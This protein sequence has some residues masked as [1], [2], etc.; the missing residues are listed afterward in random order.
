MYTGRIILSVP[1]FSSMKFGEWDGCDVFMWKHRAY[2]HVRNKCDFLPACKTSIVGGRKWTLLRI[3]CHLTHD[4]QTACG[5][6]PGVLS[7]EIIHF[8]GK[9]SNIFQ[10]VIQKPSAKQLVV[11]TLDTLPSC[12]WHIFLK[13]SFQGCYDKKQIHCEK[14]PVENRKWGRQYPFL[15]QSLRSRTVLSRCIIPCRW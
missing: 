8:Q 4:S 1:V 15:L 10:V 6:T 9:W 7:W 5:G 13:L 11:S 12:A 3:A 14:K 2:Y